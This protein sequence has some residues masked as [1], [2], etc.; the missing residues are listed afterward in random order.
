M[1][2]VLG[3]QVCRVTGGVT[4][5]VSWQIRADTFFFFSFLQFG[6]AKSGDPFI[7]SQQYVHKTH[8]VR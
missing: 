5:G 2:V 4:F 1:P 7:T 8:H 3:P 6:N